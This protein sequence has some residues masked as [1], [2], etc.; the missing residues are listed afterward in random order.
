MIS[1][2]LLLAYW[3][4]IDEDK[5]CVDIISQL[6]AARNAIKTIELGVLETHMAAC[7]TDT[8]YSK[9]DNLKKERIADDY[10]A[11]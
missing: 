3:I 7:V 4:V 11:S 9:D 6:R 8:C 2:T 5:Y 10:D 1:L